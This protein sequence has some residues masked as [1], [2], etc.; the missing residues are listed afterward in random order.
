MNKK[1]LLRL[2][3]I[4][5]FISV[6]AVKAYADRVVYSYDASGNRIQSQK[7]I[8]LRDAENGSDQDTIPLRESLSSH[9]ITIYPNPTKGQ[10]SV[11]ITG[12]AI[13]DNSSISIYSLQGS[14]IY[15]NAEPDILNEIDLSSQPNGIYMLRIM[16][17]SETSTWKIIKN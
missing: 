3:V 1:D 5:L 9:R 17:D 7:Q 6:I 2:F 11:E 15:Q 10:F 16:I 4:S 13:P 12:S 8:R 14:V